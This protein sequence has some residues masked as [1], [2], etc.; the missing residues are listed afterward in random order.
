PKVISQTLPQVLRRTGRFAGRLR[1]LKLNA[2]RIVR[3]LARTNP[4]GP[5][6]KGESPGHLVEK[7]LLIPVLKFAHDAALH[8]QCPIRSLS[9]GLLAS[10]AHITNYHNWKHEQVS[11]RI[12]LSLALRT[13]LCF[14]PVSGMA[15]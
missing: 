1:R 12:D 8:V 5:G 2:P 14:P 13:V 15:L 7:T 11:Y 4:A 6:F 3:G 10:S 9:S